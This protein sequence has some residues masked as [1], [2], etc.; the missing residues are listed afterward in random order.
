[1][2]NGMTRRERQ[3]TDIHEIRR[4]LDNARIVHIGMVDDGEPYVIPMNYGYTLEGEA[5]TLY[6]HGAMR[7]RKID[8]MRK[9]P[10]VF[11]SLECDVTPFEGD[12][13]CRYGTAYSS[14]LGKG[15]AE[16]LD[17][18]EA[19]KQGLSILMK[20]QTGKDFTFDDKT[21]SVVQVIK[22][23]IDEYTAKY[24]PMPKQ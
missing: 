14:I 20:T 24:R 18:I 9:S 12:I 23:P 2:A 15:K 13:A 16:L 6:L 10:S 3:I 1:M 19:K 7:G 21:V 4:I 8:V 22:I 11:F 5:L 17:D